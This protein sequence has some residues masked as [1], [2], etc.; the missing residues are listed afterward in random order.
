MKLGSKAKAFQKRG[1]AW[2]CTL[3]L[4]SD[5]NKNVLINLS[6]FIKSIQVVY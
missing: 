6:F 3:G 2:F 1:Q 5:I 4:A